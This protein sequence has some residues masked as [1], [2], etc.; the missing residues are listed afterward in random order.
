MGILPE[1]RKAGYSVQEVRI[2]RCSRPQGGRILHRRLSPDRRRTA[3]RACRAAIW[4]RSIYRTIE[5]RVETIFGNSIAAIEERDDG[6]CVSFEHGPPREF[7]LVI[8][9]DGLHSTVRGL[10]FGPE[11]Q[12][13]KQLGYHVAAFEVDGYRPRDELVYVAYTMPGRQV[14][15]FALRGDRTCSSSSSSAST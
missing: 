3:S 5:G 13:E 2:G 7:D 6:V 14:A 9:A 4:P 1:V 12:F 11:S 8:G 10:V 15:R